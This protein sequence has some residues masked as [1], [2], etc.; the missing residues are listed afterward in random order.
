MVIR[1]CGKQMR[2]VARHPFL[3]GPAKGLLGPC[4]DSRLRIGGDVR[5][6][7]GAK[8]CPHRIAACEGAAAL[9][10]VTLRAK[11]S[12][13]QHFAA[14]DKF[15]C[16]GGWDGRRNRRNRWSPGKIKSA[17]DSDEQNSR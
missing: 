7:D 3:H 12:C 14:H 17:D 1:K 13:G 11:T 10:R 16:K 9:R 15:T 8:S 5:R 2:S 6:I 4:T